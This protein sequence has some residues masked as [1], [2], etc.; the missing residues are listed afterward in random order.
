MAPLPPENTARFFVDYQQ[1]WAKHTLLVRVAPTVTP[2]EFASVMNNVW[3]AIAPLTCLTL[4]LAVRYAA[5]GSVVS[6]PVA[7]PL[8]NTSFGSGNPQTEQL[9]SYID[10]VGR[11]PS[12]RRVRLTFFGIDIGLSGFRFTANENP[13]IPTLVSTFN[14]AQSMFLAIDGTKPVFKNYANSGVHAYWTKELRA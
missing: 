3:T 14:D 5:L 10:F 1:A 9:A 6:N 13:A 7:T 11:S 8:T 12:G 2:T 4:I